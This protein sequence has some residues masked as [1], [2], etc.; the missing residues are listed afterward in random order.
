MSKKNAVIKQFQDGIINNNPVLVQLLGICPVLA[1]TTSAVNALSMGVL[2]VT[3]LVC[4]NLLMSFL[5]KRIPAQIRIVSYIVIISGIVSL[6]DLFMRAYLP[7]ISNSLGI[8]VPLIVVNCIILAGYDVATSE[9]K[10]LPSFVDSLTVGL[11]FAIALV[12]IGSIREVLGLGT[13]FGV[14]VFGSWF[15]PAVI[16]VMAPGAFMVLGF[17]MAFWRKVRERRESYAKQQ[18]NAERKLEREALV[19]EE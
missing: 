1:T 13:I 18:E 10:V 12:V 8:F 17:V 11:G 7:S 14:N 16:F 19:W 9:K 5:R 15:E 4:S 2:T 6:L 3:L